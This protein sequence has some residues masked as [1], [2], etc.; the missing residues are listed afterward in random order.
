MRINSSLGL[1]PQFTLHGKGWGCGVCGGGFAAPTNPTFPYL[2][3][4]LLPE[5]D[6]LHKPNLSKAA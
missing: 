2:T 5:R 4:M 6:L 3:G 1:A